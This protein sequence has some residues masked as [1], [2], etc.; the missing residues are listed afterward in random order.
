VSASRV[1]HVTR[2]LDKHSDRTQQPSVRW[3]GRSIGKDVD[4]GGAERNARKKKQQSQAQAAVAA[5]RGTNRDRNKIIIGVVVVLVL[6]V[7]VIGGVVWSKSSSSQPT[8]AAA[9][10]AVQA[11]AKREDGTVLVGKDSAKTTVDVY[12]DFLCPVC[13]KFEKIYGDQIKKE[14]EG[15]TIKVRYHVL[16][17]LVRASNPEGYSR[18]SANAALC[19]ADAGKFNAY[20]ASLFNSQPKEGG[21][22]YT[23]QQLIK[24]GNDVGITGDTF[25]QC[26]NNGTYEQA[27]QAEL[28]KANQT[29]FFK[30]TPTVTVGDK[31]VDVSN[32]NWLSD[33]VRNA[34]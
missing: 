21:A 19:A 27:A 24:L 4:V 20:H 7:A 33:I 15:G 1:L 6:A 22:G 2:R 31:V 3:L 14:V 32:S 28:D 26:V 34:N 25:T 10:T 18:D 16:P 9:T 30:G 23:K 8:A 17:M 13:G 12:E 5:A 11:P 29:S